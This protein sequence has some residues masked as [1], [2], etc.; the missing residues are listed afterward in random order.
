[1]LTRTRNALVLLGLVAAFGAGFA[2]V[3]QRRP[4]AVLGGRALAAIPSGAL[5]VATADLAALRAS[6]AG[7]PFLREGREIPGVG[8][9][10]DVCGFDPMD[11][12]TEVALAIPAADDTGEFGLSA[13]GDIDA[14]A[15]LACASKVIEGRGGRPVVTSIGSFRS[16]RDATA[17]AS[18]GEIAVRKGGP[19]LLGGGV[20]FRA[21]IDAADGRTPAIRDSVPHSHLAE[22]VGDASVRITVV[23]TPALRQVLAE[24]LASNSE[25]GSPA[26]AIAAGALG[27][28]LGSAVDLHGVIE[29][30]GDNAANAAKN[31]AG[32]LNA[33]RLDRASDFATRLVGFGAVFEQLQIEPKGRAIHARV[34]MPTDQAVTL[35]ERLVTLR[36]VRHPMPDKPPEPLQAAPR[37]SQSAAPPPPATSGAPPRPDEV[38]APGDGRPK[39]SRPD[40]G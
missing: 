1:V 18:S 3:A 15:L 22:E 27:V 26:T 25:A 38:I 35:A 24:E 8:K 20:Y 10:R 12:L 31:L 7:A 2:W 23:L 14:E 29:C 37:G 13:A 28:K 6:P 4:A 33:A 32:T 16:V 17:G 19:L 21:M 34:S 39:K 30:D 40:G 9:V 5:L 11:T 36:S